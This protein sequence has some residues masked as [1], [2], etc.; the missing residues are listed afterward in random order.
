MRAAVEG[1]PAAI[2]RFIKV[3]R[4]EL[5]ATVPPASRKMT[6]THVDTP[7][8]RVFPDFQWLELNAAA[9]AHKRKDM[10]RTTVFS[11]SLRFN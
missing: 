9:N 1:T 4:T 11:V 8:T 3:T 2:A 10:V 7:I 5:F 6:L